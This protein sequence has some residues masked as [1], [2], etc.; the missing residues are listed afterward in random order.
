MADAE[1]A[2]GHAIG[3][4]LD[5]GVW[6]RLRS[7]L[8]PSAS[9]GALDRRRG[10]HGAV[11]FP[12]RRHRRPLECIRRSSG[13]ARSRSAATRQF[14]RARNGG[15]RG[16]TSS[17]LGAGA[18]RGRGNHRRPDSYPK[19]CSHYHL[20]RVVGRLLV[21]VRVRRKRLVRRQSVGGG[22]RLV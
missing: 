21:R 15:F 7:A 19:S 17:G 20:D 4:L 14:G 12:D 22:L 13:S 3:I 6:T 9:P 1:R 16:A 8:R 10:V 11:V 2:S 5:T 18:R